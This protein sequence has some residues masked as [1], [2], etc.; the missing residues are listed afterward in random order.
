VVHKHS[1][2]KGQKKKKEKSRSAFSGKNGF[3]NVTAGKRGR[4]KNGKADKP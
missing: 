4:G 3:E 1:A 2:P